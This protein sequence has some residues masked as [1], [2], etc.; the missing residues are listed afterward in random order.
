MTV[1]KPEDFLLNRALFSGVPTLPRS[2]SGR[3]SMAGSVKGWRRIVFSLRS[4]RY[5]V[6]P[7]G[8]NLF[9]RFFW[10]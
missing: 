5:Q 2:P 3:I 4:Q 8:A 1:Q 10:R 9:R 7:A 6:I